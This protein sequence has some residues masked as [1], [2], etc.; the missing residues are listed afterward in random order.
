[1][2]WKTHILI[3]MPTRDIS[4]IRL[5]LAELEDWMSVK[6]NE[7]SSQSCSWPV[8]KTFN[9]TFPSELTTPIQSSRRASIDHIPQ[10]LSLSCLTRPQERR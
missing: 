1:M 8:P 5:S 4:K 9:C 10:V 7:T 3:Y 6:T 2:V